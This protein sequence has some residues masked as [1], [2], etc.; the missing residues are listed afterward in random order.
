M[1]DDISD[2]I[3]RE[4]LNGSEDLLHFISGWLLSKVC[5][6]KNMQGLTPKLRSE[7]AAFNPLTVSD[8]KFSE[9]PCDE[10]SHQENKLGVLRRP[11]AAWFQFTCLLESL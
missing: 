1:V 6:K 7:F 8:A 4:R 5:Q 11:G 10:I 9:I 3:I 2:E